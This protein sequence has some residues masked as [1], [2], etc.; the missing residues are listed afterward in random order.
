MSRTIVFDFDGTLADTWDQTI[1]L[2]KKHAKF[3][4]EDVDYF[5]KN[6][7]LKTIAKLK[8]PPLQ[9]IQKT[10]QIQKEQKSVIDEAKPF[11]G[12]KTLMNDIRSMNNEVGI[13]SANST[14]NIKKW[15]KKWDMQVDFVM[16]TSALL[17][18]AKILKEIK[19][20]DMIYV[21]DEVRDIEACKKAGVP[22]IAVT[23]GFND[24]EALIDAKPDWMAKTVEG[25]M[26]IINN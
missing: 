14:E 13:L 1:E 5:R 15:L 2:L 23:W 20:D 17:G 25:I 7:A 12:I 9:L 26:Q 24:M 18:K 4:S 16:T 8:I 22:V 3:D 10:I 6:G 11:E 21:G 19:T